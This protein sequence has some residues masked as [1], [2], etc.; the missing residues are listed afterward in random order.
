MKNSILLSNFCV[1][2]IALTLNHCALSADIFR[3]EGV[4]GTILY[5][6]QPLNKS[7]RIFM[8]GDVQKARMTLT[9]P[10]KALQARV[11]TTRNV[12]DSRIV[13]L[14]EQL[15][16]KHQVDPVLIH[17]VMGVESNA[18]PNAVSPKGAAGLMQLMPTTAVMYG[19]TNLND[20]AQNIE[21]GILHLKYLLGL[22]KGNIALTLAAYNAGEGAVAKNSHRIPPYRETMLYV[23]AVLARMQAARN[24]A[25][26]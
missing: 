22:H 4:D 5:S 11:S 24:L 10:T 26:R 14:V 15:A 25:A 9:S 6:S 2:F 16:Q 13:A 21:A 7:Y 8:R 18:N 17:A 1:L 12:V 19:V 3:S 20:P 23:P